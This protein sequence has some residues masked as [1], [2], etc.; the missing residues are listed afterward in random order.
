M[1]GLL[2]MIAA[3]ISTRFLVRPQSTLTILQANTTKDLGDTPASKQNEPF[4]NRWDERFSSSAARGELGGYVFFKHMRKAG[5]TTIRKYIRD[6]FEYHGLSR[7]ASVYEDMVQNQTFNREYDITYIEHEYEAMDWNCRK[8]DR[9][10]QQSLNIIV[11]R[12]PIERHMSEFFFSGVTKSRKN[13]VFGTNRRIIQPDQ[14]F[15]NQTYTNILAEFIAEEVPHWMK[16]SKKENDRFK[17]RG[18]MFHRWYQDNFQLR[19]LAGCSSGRCLEM[20]LAEESID[21]KSI[22]EWHPLNHS[23]THNAICTHYFRDDSRA[24]LLFDVCNSQRRDKQC[25][26]GCDGPCFYPTVAT[27][28]LDK[29][30]VER[31]IK[32]LQ[33]FDAILLM[34]KLKEEEQSAF[35]SD[36]MGVPRDETFALKN[37]RG[38]NTRVFKWNNRQVSHYYRDLLSNLNLKRV[39]RLLEEQNKLEM[40][41]YYRALILHDKQMKRWREESGWSELE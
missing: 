24:D 38:L 4:V 22:Y 19:A 33:E 7:N 14:L 9:R 12:H 28:T 25:S 26:G 18:E 10:W 32:A 21:T 20:K 31:A 11:L 15:L 8:M 17:K 40:E 6:V 13:E 29:G 30:D 3:V 23:Y 2:V 41:F 39:L 16:H 35:I 34:E 37:A 1:L 27:G 36:V 5:G